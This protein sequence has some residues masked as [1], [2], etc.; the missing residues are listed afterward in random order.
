LV[1]TPCPG[2]NRKA[3]TVIANPLYVFDGYQLR[4]ALSVVRGANP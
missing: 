4:C 2:N 3:D 1:V